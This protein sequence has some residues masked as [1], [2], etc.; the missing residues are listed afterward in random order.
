M[1]TIRVFIMMLDGT[2]EM[3]FSYQILLWDQG[4]NPPVQ[5]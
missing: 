2:R 5:I 1:N 3:N 4:M